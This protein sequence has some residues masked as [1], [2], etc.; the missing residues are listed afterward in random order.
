[1]SSQNTEGLQGTEIDAEPDDMLFGPKCYA[2]AHV[3]IHLVIATFPSN[4]PKHPMLMRAHLELNG[5]SEEAHGTLEHQGTASDVECVKG[6]A[7]GKG[8]HAWYLTGLCNIYLIKVKFTCGLQSQ[9][10][11]PKSG[12][13]CKHDYW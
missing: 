3:H 13:F 2:S 12:V 10:C 9:P 7:R 4:V 6:L 1:M 11:K 5:L 8:K